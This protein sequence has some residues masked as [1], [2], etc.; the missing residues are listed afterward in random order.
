MLKL[1]KLKLSAIISVISSI[2]LIPTAVFAKDT[3]IFKEIQKYVPDDNTEKA[4]HAISP[5][6]GFFAFL[7]SVAA[8][9]I[10]IYTVLCIIG[11]AG[12]V[13]KGKDSFTNKWIGETAAV[14]IICLLFGGTAGLKLF[15]YA[16]VL[17]VDTAVKTIEQ[18]AEK[19]QENQ[20]ASNDEDDGD[21]EDKDSKSA[22]P[23]ANKKST[24]QDQKK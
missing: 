18:G 24:N 3:N 9:I 8:L 14:L 23:T 17:L 22:T 12:K 16:K 2:F 11:K 20:P 13:K 19:A 1:S 15:E 10:I 21:E 6:I 4:V 7:V 5:V